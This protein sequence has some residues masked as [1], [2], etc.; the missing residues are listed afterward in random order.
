[1][2]PNQLHM[3]TLLVILLMLSLGVGQAQYQVYPSHWFTG[4]KDHELNLIVRGEGV[5]NYTAASIQYPGVKLVKIRKA[6]SDNYLFLDLLI[7]PTAKPGNLNIELTGKQTDPRSIAYELKARSSANGKSRIQGVRAEDFIYLIMT[8]RFAN[9]NTDN[10]IVTGYLDQTCDRTDKFSRH[11]GDF[12]PES[13]GG[14]N[15]LAHP[16]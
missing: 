4:F 5:A 1:M 12:K 10:D 16:G 13:A 3:R 2:N 6:Q 14:H 8:D 11:G 9:G 15:T 7:D